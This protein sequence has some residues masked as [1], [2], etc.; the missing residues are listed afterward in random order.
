MVKEDRIKRKMTKVKK[1]SN[2]GDKLRISVKNSVE[3]PIFFIYYVIAP[4]L[5]QNLILIPNIILLIFSSFL[6][7]E[8]R[9]GR[10]FT[11]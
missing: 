9:R 4:E 3:S 10:R 8:K 2:I 7:R 1:T 5:L 6:V 11:V